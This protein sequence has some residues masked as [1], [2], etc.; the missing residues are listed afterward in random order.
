MQY[1]STGGLSNQDNRV[2]SALTGT[3]IEFNEFIEF[4]KDNDA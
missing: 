3:V 1:I 4:Y 2:F